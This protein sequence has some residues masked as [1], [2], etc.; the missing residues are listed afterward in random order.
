VEANGDVRCGEGSVM[1][2]P[3]SRAGVVRIVSRKSKRVRVDNHHL[4]PEW[5][6]R[7]LRR[8][9][10]WILDHPY[11]SAAIFALLLACTGFALRW[12]LGDSLEDNLFS[13]GISSLIWLA[14]SPLQVR[15]LRRRYRRDN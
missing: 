14:F 8:F 3:S 13:T 1:E 7:S 9:D 4:P 10:R 12:Y 6:E 11:R 15:L 5:G 2:D